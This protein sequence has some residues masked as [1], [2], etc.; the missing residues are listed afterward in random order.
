M[1]DSLKNQFEEFQENKSPVKCTM[2]SPTKSAVFFNNKSEVCVSKELSFTADDIE[3]MTVEEI[4]K[5]TI[6]NLQR[7]R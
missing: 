4:N 7:N 2:V 5:S 1:D 3:P 6:G